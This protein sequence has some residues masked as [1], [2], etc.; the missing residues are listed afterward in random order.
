MIQTKFYRITGA[1]EFHSHGSC[2][3]FGIILYSIPVLL[4]NYVSSD[5]LKLNLR[6]H[7]FPLL[8]TSFFIEQQWWNIQRHDIWLSSSTEVG[9]LIGRVTTKPLI[10]LNLSKVETGIFSLVSMGLHQRLQLCVWFKMWAT[11]A[12]I[13][14]LSLE[15][16]LKH[17]VLNK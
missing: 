16:A 15:N 6:M 14:A 12:P 3:F 13:R 11:A 9:G 4:W 7:S 10:C 2:K 1:L 5:V 17:I 8:I